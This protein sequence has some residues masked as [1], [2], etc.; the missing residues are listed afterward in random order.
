MSGAVF[1]RLRQLA[2]DGVAFTVRQ[3]RLHDAGGAR[4]DK[5]ADSAPAPTSARGIDG[6]EETIL[7][8]GKFRQSVIAAVEYAKL[9]RQTL[10]IDTRNL[11][12]VRV[13]PDGL[14]IAVGQTAALRHQTGQRR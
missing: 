2:A 14:K 8:Q 6:F 3:F 7:L 4:A 1:E 5:H 11:A 10:C 9:R 13:D 12:D